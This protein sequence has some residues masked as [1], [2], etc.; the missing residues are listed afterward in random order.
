MIWADGI[1]INQEDDIEKGHQ[2]RFM[3]EIY[4][5]AA[6]VTFWLGEESPADQDAFRALDIL[7][8]NLNNLGSMNS[9]AT[10]WR[11]KKDDPL[12]GM[13]LT[14]PLV[15]IEYDHLAAHL[16]RDWFC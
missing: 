8:L 3:R 9:N 11:R 4:E 5:S 6:Q 7:E 2:V 14:G 13:V 1:C 15:D 10:S 12:S 16:R